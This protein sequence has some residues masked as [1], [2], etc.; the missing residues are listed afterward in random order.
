M[1]KY[2]STTLKMQAFCFLS[3]IKRNLEARS[4]PCQLFIHEIIVEWVRLT[5]K[6]K[7]ITRSLYSWYRNISISPWSFKSRPTEGYIHF[8]AQ[9][10]QYSPGMPRIAEKGKF[11]SLRLGLAFPHQIWHSWPCWHLV[12]AKSK[13]L[14]TKRWQRKLKLKLKKKICQS[15]QSTVPHDNR[16]CLFSVN[17]Q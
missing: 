3:W 16:F 7:K 1:P 8:Q 6:K 4:K 2:L 12:K 10:E 9:K 17:T 15:F 14:P 13:L 11:F 5:K